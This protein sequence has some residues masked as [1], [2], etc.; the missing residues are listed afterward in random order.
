MP[1]IV[2][3]GAAVMEAVVVVVVVVV[4]A[5]Q[6]KF[7]VSVSFSCCSTSSIEEKSDVADVAETLCSSPSVLEKVDPIVIVICLLIRK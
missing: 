3:V 5:V 6:F 1:L 4:V 2:T 7:F